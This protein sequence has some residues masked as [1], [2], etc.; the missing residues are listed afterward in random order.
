[1]KMGT[2]DPIRVL[3]ASVDSSL[4]QSRAM[5]LRH[6]GLDV[7]TSES[8]EHARQL[9]A[10]RN[11]DVLIFGSTLPSDTCWQLAEV[12]RQRNANGRIIEILPSPWAAPKNRPD[13]TVVSSDEATELIS[14]VRAGTGD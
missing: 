2:E 13:A 3:S 8:L 10:E 5:L 11:F 4:N 6:H 1:M 12:F 7:K 9:I 14:I